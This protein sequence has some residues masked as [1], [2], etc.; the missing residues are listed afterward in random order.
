MSSRHFHASSIIVHRLSTILL[1]IS[2]SD[3]QNA[4]GKEGTTGSARAFAKLTKWARKTP[5]L[6][7]QVVCHAIKTILM[8]APGEDHMEG[9]IR[10]IDTAPYSLITIFLCHIVVWAFAN[11]A[12][13]SQKVQLLDVV[14][15]SMDVRST[16][17][18]A[19]LKRSLGFDG[20]AA[21]RMRMTGQEHEDQNE[22][23]S[24]AAANLLFRSAAE[25]MIRLGTWGAALNLAQLLHERA[26]M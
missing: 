11:V 14:S 6:A 16:P 12:I 5:H 8:L 10:N 18:F 7:E 24:T 25:K 20:N 4:I 2:L 23:N 19:T 9:G 22:Q 3:L 13:Q 1:D 15:K 17:F 21:Q 26:E